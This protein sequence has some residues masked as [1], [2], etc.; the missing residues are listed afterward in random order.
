M[1]EYSADGKI[2]VY[3]G[4]RFR[5]DP[6]TGYYLCTRK[7]DAGR[8]ER[9]HVYVWR[10]NCGQI[11]DGYHIHHKDENK[12]NNDL[13]NLACIPGKIHSTF[14]SNER[15]ANN[16]D[17]I[18]KNLNENVRPAARAWHRG[19]AGKE[20]HRTHNAEYLHITREFVCEYCGKKYVGVVNGKNR[21]CSNKCRSAY[22]RKIGA[23]NETRICECCK[24]PFEVNKYEKTVV[25]SRS[26]AAVLRWNKAKGGD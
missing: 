4:Y 20:W 2:A 6:N 21:F 25:C 18:I 3:D 5:K 12:D 16:Y 15:V 11:P 26:C 14:H 13:E 17:A 9:L 10:K 1:I 19:G 24:K 8:R 22:R 7:T 23:D